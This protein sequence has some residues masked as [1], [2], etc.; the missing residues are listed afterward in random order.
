MI[1]RLGFALGLLLLLNSPRALGAMTLADRLVSVQSWSSYLTFSTA[2]QTVKSSLCSGITTVQRLASTGVAQTTGTLTVNLSG[3][4]TVTFYSDSSCTA[5]ITSV[6]IAS[7]NSTASFY[8]IDTAAETSPLVASATSYRSV[9]QNETIGTNPFVWT[10]GGGNAYWAT[11]LNWSGGTAPNS[12]TAIAIF[13]GTCSSNCSPN[14][15]AT[16]ATNTLGGVRINSPYAGTITQSAGSLINIGTS[17]WIQNAGSSTFTGSAGST[18]NITDTGP[19]A[20]SAG[21]FTATN[22]TLSVGTSFIV[23]NTPTFNANGG[24]VKFTASGTPTF[25]PG[26]ISFQNV[27]FNSNNATFNLTG[28]MTIAGN[29]TFDD[30]HGANAGTLNGGTVNV[31]GNVTA[32]EWGGGTSLLTLV[33]TG[34]QTVTGGGTTNTLPSM[35]IASS[36]TVSFAGTAIAINSTF[37]YTS[38]TVNVNS[39]PVIFST[40]SASMHTITP[41]SISF[42]NVTFYAASGA[43]QYTISG[44]MTVT[45]SLTLNE[46]GTTGALTGGTINVAGGITDTAWS[47]VA[48]TTAINWVGSGTQTLTGTSSASV[49]NLAINGTG[50]LNFSGTT[51]QFTD[52]FSYNGSGTV[53]VGT[54]NVVFLSSGEANFPITPG[55]IAFQTVTFNNPSGSAAY[56]IT[57]T[58]SAVNVTTY[59]GSSYGLKFLTGTI[60]VSGNYTHASGPDTSSTATL[61]FSGTGIQTWTDSGTQVVPFSN[62]VVNS[63]ST[64]TLASNVLMSNSSTQNLNVIAGAVNMAGYNLTLTNSQLT[65]NGNTITKN[66]G[67]LTVGGSTSPYGGT[68]NP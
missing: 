55:A 50:T 60:S 15:A 66:G 1:C 7:G 68:V 39:V 11:G 35:V 25:T 64:V 65:L 30:I 29:V 14:I 41:G 5:A 9:K 62:V 54:S 24:T 43:L 6:T 63:S 8:F 59:V 21:T 31:S 3:D 47:D 51:V 38:G 27:I 40:T 36:G 49:P 45:G 18:D 12:S 37:T 44:T 4:G 57:G 19:F 32:T 2:A 52:S 56:T 46:A 67:T 48:S 58:L 61:L 34:T 10:G 17:G 33:G 26:S 53:N 23:N 13:D 20:L 16:I 42:A 22:G 28:T